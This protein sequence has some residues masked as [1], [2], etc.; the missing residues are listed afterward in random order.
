MLNH[1]RSSS[2]IFRPF[3]CRIAQFKIIYI[4]TITKKVKMGAADVPA[5]GNNRNR[6]GNIVISEP[7]VG[8]KPCIMHAAFLFSKTF[9][10]NQ[11]YLL[12]RLVCVL[13]LI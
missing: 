10:C 6:K 5:K 11:L 4:L 3:G 9:Q 8:F 7:E 2:T 13:F 12:C 1:K